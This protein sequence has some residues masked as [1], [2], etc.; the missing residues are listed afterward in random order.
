MFGSHMLISA[1]HWPSVQV[2]LFPQFSDWWRIWSTEWAVNNQLHRIIYA[3]VYIRLTVMNVQKWVLIENLVDLCWALSCFRRWFGELVHP[4]S[5]K[6]T[7]QKNGLVCM[8]L[9]ITGNDIVN[10]VQF[11]HRL[12]FFH[13]TSI[14]RQEPQGFILCSL[15]CFYDDAAAICMDHVLAKSLLHTFSTKKQ[16]KKNI[17]YILDGLRVSKY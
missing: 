16:K 5:L 12:L 6:R 4:R 9:W 2:E 10:N 11:L 8:R 13:K 17:I 1:A 14:H 7:V 15:M 3:G